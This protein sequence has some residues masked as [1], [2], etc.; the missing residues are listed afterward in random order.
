MYA[1]QDY[2]EVAIVFADFTPNFISNHERRELYVQSLNFIISTVKFH[3]I[4]FGPLYTQNLP[5]TENPK[6]LRYMQNYRL[7]V[8]LAIELF[9][10]LLMAFSFVLNYR[11]SHSRVSSN[12]PTEWVAE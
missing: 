10:R 4:Y 7:F 8:H 5:I 11:A 9:V 3:V 12:F 6:L 1:S 2:F